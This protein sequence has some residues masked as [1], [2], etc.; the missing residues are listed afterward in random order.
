MFE[1]AEELLVSVPTQ[2][3]RQPQALR[4][5]RQ[6]RDEDRCII[7]HLWAAG[8]L[9]I[10]QPVQSGF[11]GALPP[12]IHRRTR[13]PG[14]VSDIRIRGAL[15]CEKHD[16]GSIQVELYEKADNNCNVQPSHG[17]IVEI[18]IAST[19]GLWHRDRLFYRLRFVGT[20]A[21][22]H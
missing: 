19:T 3:V 13:D 10:N 9:G 5:W 7:E 1:E 12:Q 15:G 2:P 21:P 22:H 11:Q 17:N 4:W 6:R 16:P 18:L 20:P 8:S 14:E